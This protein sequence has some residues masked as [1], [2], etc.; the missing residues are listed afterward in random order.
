VLER[1]PDAAIMASA[2][3]VGRRAVE[4]GFMRGFLVGGS[5]S[6]VGLVH[7]TGRQTL[8]RDDEA[9]SD[10]LMRNAQHREGSGR[11]ATK[12]NLSMEFFKAVPR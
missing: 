2:K 1:K 10:I 3:V 9:L 7:W 5:G 8:N 12:L 4:V 6:G 11:P